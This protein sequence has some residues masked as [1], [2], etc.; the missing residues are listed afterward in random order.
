MDAIQ[1]V[2]DEELE[3]LRVIW[4][5]YRQVVQRLNR[6]FDRLERVRRVLDRYGL[7]DE[8]H[9]GSRDLLA[10]LDETPQEGK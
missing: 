5:E 4:N 9:N 7:L 6:E 8:S 2:R 3:R 1:A 10:A